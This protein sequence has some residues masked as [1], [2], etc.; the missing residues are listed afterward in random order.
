MGAVSLSPWGNWDYELWA[1]NDLSLDTSPGVLINKGQMFLENGVKEIPDV[2][3]VS[4]NEDSQSVV[5]LTR[6][7]N[8]CAVWN[9][10]PDIWNLSP[11]IWNNCN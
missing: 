1:I 8:D 7:L 6:N 11:L 3:Y 9:T 10:F 5:Y 2:T 4:D